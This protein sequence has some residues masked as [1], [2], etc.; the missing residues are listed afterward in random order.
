[1]KKYDDHFKEKACRSVINGETVTEVA[2]RLNINTNTLYGWV[3]K[4]KKMHADILKYYR[5][6]EN[7]NSRI[8]DRGKE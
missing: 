8:I 7:V 6:I 5:E 4:Y 3:S 2:N 1:M